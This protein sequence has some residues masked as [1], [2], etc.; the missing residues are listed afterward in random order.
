VSEAVDLRDSD[1]AWWPAV[2]AV[3]RSGKPG[4]GALNQV[5]DGSEPLSRSGY[6]VFARAGCAEALVPESLLV[7]VGPRDQRC[8]AC[9]SQVFFVDRRGRAL[10]YYIY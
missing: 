3:W 8:A 6:A 7:V 1:R 5:V 9:R 2:R 4:N 10:I